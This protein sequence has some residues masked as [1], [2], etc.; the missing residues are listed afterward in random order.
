MMAPKIEKYERTRDLMKDVRYELL[1]LENFHRCTR[2]DLR[3]LRLRYKC[4]VKY[5]PAVADLK[6]EGIDYKSVSDLSDLSL[7]TS[8]SKIA[9]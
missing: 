8:L 2:E 3:R 1:E 4:L 9:K 6:Q 5:K 7:F